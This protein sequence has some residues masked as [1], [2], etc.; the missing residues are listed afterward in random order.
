MSIDDA[1]KYYGNGNR[2]CNAL[3]ISRTNLTHWRKRGYMP[4]KQQHILQELTGGVLKAGL[5]GRE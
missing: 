5:E 1:I 4:L 2:L 3:R